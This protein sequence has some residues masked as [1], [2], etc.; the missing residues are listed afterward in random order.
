[1]CAARNGRMAAGRQRQTTLWK[2][3]PNTGP[4]VGPREPPSLLRSLLLASGALLT[5]AS[6]GLAQEPVDFYRGKIITLA[7]STSSGGDYD[8]RARLLA[9]HMTRHIPGAPKF[10][11]QNMPGGGGLRGANWLYNVAAQDGT[12]LAALQQQIPLSQLFKKSGVEF[13]MAKF[14]FIGNTSASP[15]VIMSWGASPIK[16]F[17]DVFNT[18]FVVGGTGGGSASVQIPLMLNAV[19]GAKF[20]VVPGYPGGSE[21]YLAM[22]R[23]EIAG[24]VT[25]SWAGWKAQKPDW[26]AEKK[27]LPLAQGGRKRHAELERTPLISDF[28]RNAE[29]R[30]LIQFMLSSDEVARPIIAAPGTPADRVSVLRGAFM[31]TMLDPDFQADADKL[32][33]DIEAMSGEEAQ[34]IV[35]DMMSAPAKIIERAKTYMGSDG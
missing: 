14:H 6:S 29:D 11:V 27:I 13:D 9:R 30:Q 21:I 15:I 7:V 3:T 28:A 32:K 18:E 4:K 17:A 34:A 31:A 25:Q 35:N 16:S 24:R 20:K 5:F 1:M 23:G 8:T 10:V 12:A 19:I 2:A 33:L 26:I 22:E